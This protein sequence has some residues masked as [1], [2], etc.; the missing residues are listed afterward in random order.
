MNDDKSKLWLP[1]LFGDG[2]VVQQGAP[3]A[4]WGK[5]YPGENVTVRFN[6]QEKRTSAS[7]D[8]KWTLK[9]DPMPYGGPYELQ[10]AGEQNI[11]T[12]SD[13]YVGEVWLCG[14]QSN[15]EWKLAK[16]AYY[17]QEKAKAHYPGIRFINV[18]SAGADEPQEDIKEAYWR[19][20][21]PETA[22]MVTGVGYYFAA[23]LHQALNVP[24]GIILSSVGG[25]K[26]SSWVKRETL[27]AHPELATFLDTYEKECAAN[28]PLRE[29]YRQQDS[30]YK[31]LVEL[32]A[33]YGQTIAPANQLVGPPLMG[34]ANPKRPSALYN[35]MIA[36]LQPF[37]I[38]GALWYQ[39]E[40]DAGTPQL[41]AEL[42]RTLIGEWRS[43]FDQG[44]F[45]FF[46][47]QLPNYAAGT[48]WPQ[49]REAQHQVALE[50]NGVGIVGTIDVGQWD[51]IHPTDKR[52]VGERLAQLARK[53]VYG[54]DVLCQGPVCSSAEA[55]SGG[56]VTLSFEET[57]SGLKSSTPIM[58]GFEICGAD[59]VY[60]KAAAILVNKQQIIAASPKVTEPAGV[61]YAWA[62]NPACSLFNQE[63]LPSMPFRVSVK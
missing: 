14:G 42:L 54:Q 56:K 7:A 24:V 4:V 15:M 34:P 21:S 31:E 37:T 10:I 33:Q 9:L 1:R 55:G 51:D 6:G 23:M 26:I 58:H 35:A 16:T 62:A 22:G 39:G 2:M 32:A 47:V 13:V 44:D 20:V 40:S 36:P 30:A 57:G 3:V 46:V 48:N 59:G 12:L 60:H 19:Q 38:K 41:Y 53:T 11:I 8:G 5:A 17:E 49:I 61:R 45:P 18:P 29:R 28:D 50:T 25:T 27:Q 52:P 43:G 63:G